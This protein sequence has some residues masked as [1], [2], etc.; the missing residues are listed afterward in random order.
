MRLSE[1]FYIFIAYVETYIKNSEFRKYVLQSQPRHIILIKNVI[2]DTVKRTNVI[3]R[4]GSFGNLSLNVLKMSSCLQ[5]ESLGAVSTYD[6][7]FCGGV[8]L[9]MSLCGGVSYESVVLWLA[10]LLMSVSFVAVSFS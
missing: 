5:L 9:T 6:S 10:C 1:V 8:F 4:H 3:I 7:V 2:N